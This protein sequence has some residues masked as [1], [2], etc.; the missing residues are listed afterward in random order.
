MP[1]TSINIANT[2][3]RSS[4]TAVLDESFRSLRITGSLL[5]RESY[6]IPWAVSIPNARDLSELLHNESNNHVVAFHLVEFGHCE[7]QTDGKE[8]VLLTAGDIAICFGKTAHT[9]GLGKSA[10]HQPIA[11]LLSGTSNACNPA[12]TKELAA[13]SLI[14]GAFQFNSSLLSPLISAM[15]SLLHVNLSKSGEMH[16]LSGVAR[17]LADEIMRSEAGSSYIT[18]RLLELLC[19]EVIRAYFENGEQPVGWFR[20]LRDP[21]VGKAIANIHAQPNASWT[22]SNLAGRVSISPSRLAARFVESMG[23]SPMAYVAQC[24]MNIACQKLTT[25][26]YS[27][28]QIAFDIGYESAA[29]FYRAFKKHLGQSPASW[30]DER[31]TGMS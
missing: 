3:Y 27:I 12:I 13:T 2:T 5:L 21:I 1:K 18:E 22:V 28:E 29:A 15:P 17:L 11:K 26:R 30:R 16:N 14:C 10:V 19:A 23:I 24:R 6:S 31:R 8:S 9:V 7:I 20:G 4:I 25:S